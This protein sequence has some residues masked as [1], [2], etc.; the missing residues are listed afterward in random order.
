MTYAFY[1][2]GIGLL[3]AS[4]R[5]LSVLADP[6]DV[7]FR[8]DEESEVADDIAR[9]ETAPRIFVAGRSLGILLTPVLLVMIVV[10]AG[11]NLRRLL[12]DSGAFADRAAHQLLD[13]LNGRTWLVSN[14]ILDPNLLICA[15]ERHQRIYLL[16]PYRAREPRYLAQVLASVEKDPG[17]TEN[18]K[19]KARSLVSFSLHL[20]IDDLFACNDS[21][22]ERVVCLGLPDLWYSADW[23]PVPERLFFGGTRNLKAL[24][25]EKLAASHGDFWKAWSSFVAQD[26][27][28]PRQLSYRHRMALRRHFSF[29]ANNLGVTLDDLGAP[30]LAFDAYLQSREFWSENISALLNL[31]DLVSRGQH[32][33][34]K[35]AIEAQLRHKVEDSSS[36]YSLWAL[37][38][39]YGYVRNYAMF[40]QMGWSWALSSSPGSVLAGLRTAFSVQD[41]E[42]KRTE[43]VALMA[44]VY[45]MRGD[46]L[47]SEQA[48]QNV[49]AVE[50]RN[51]AAIS[52]LARLAIHRNVPDD[53]RRILM[54]GESAGASKRSLRLDWAALYLAAGDLA[55][56][57]VLLQELAEEPDAPAMTLAMLAMVMIEQNESMAVES[58]ILPKLMKNTAGADAYFSQVVQGRIWQGKGAA[59]FKNARLCFHRAA[60]LRPDVHALQEVLLS[61]DVSMQ[62]QKAAEAHALTILRREPT[63]PFANYIMGSIRLEAGEY[64]DAESYLKKSV[65]TPNPALPAL[66]NYAQTLCRIRRLDEALNVAR[67]AT[68]RAPTRYE[69]WGT[70]AY[71]LAVKGE[72]VQAAEA[73]ASARALDSS[74]ARLSLVDALLA[75]QRKDRAAALKALEVTEKYPDLSV[76]DQRELLHVREAATAL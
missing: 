23:V 60:L 2:I 53:A 43:L 64:G 45:A 1:G 52:G 75:V 51:H 73:L 17:F 32:P 65:D 70:L 39:Y 3:I 48:Y 46:A 8:V 54:E 29:V 50:P 66:N 42:A 27:G 61:L 12:T 67:Q 49:L 57:R 24:Q 56:A 31:F 55:R 28:S 30:E 37:S 76:A 19:L 6:L 16:C 59:G 33:E 11:L 72:V 10:S 18:A 22:G 71:V 68:K 36:R 44:S 34:M 47:K 9:V 69:G 63:H 13:G 14:G 26:P 4:W 20:F 35:D 40:V 58:K 15:H 62:D 5:A 25:P 74:D 38:R 21:F 41:D 7:D